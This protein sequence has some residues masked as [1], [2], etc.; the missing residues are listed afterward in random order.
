MRKLGSLSALLRAPVLLSQNID[1]IHLRYS[2]TKQLRG[3]AFL[4]LF[5]HQDFKKHL[6]SIPLG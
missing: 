2:L 3:N 1:K 6:Q 4:L 5:T